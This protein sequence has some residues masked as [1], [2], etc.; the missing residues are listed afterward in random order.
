MSADPTHTFADVPPTYMPLAVTLSGS[1]GPNIRSSAAVGAIGTPSTRT[2]VAPVAEKRDAAD[3]VDVASSAAYVPDR[4][5]AV[6]SAAHCA[7][8]LGRP[9]P[10]EYG[11]DR[12]ARRP[13]N[14]V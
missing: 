10:G 11:V 12:N 13:G 7:S 1:V 14:A 6:A 8:A 9:P 5:A 4:P 2:H 3:V